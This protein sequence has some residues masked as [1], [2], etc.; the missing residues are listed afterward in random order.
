MRELLVLLV[1]DSSTLRM[2][3]GGML[4]RMSIDGVSMTIETAEDGNDAVQKCRLLRPDIVF[5]DIHMPTMSGLEAAKE[6]RRFDQ[7][8]GIFMMTSDQSSNI[9]NEAIKYRLMGYIVKPP[10]PDKLSKAINRFLS[11]KHD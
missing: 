7:E 5:M 4:K 3:V 11:K 9:V 10:N 8:V 2:V 1:D 6:I